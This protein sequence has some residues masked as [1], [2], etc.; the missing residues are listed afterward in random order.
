MKRIVICES[1]NFEDAEK[2]KNKVSKIIADCQKKEKKE[3]A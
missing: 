2:R 1:D 3:D